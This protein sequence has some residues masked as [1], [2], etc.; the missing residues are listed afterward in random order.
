M[1]SPNL[2]ELVLVESKSARDGRLSRMT[3]DA[4]NSA[5][6]KA[7]AIIFAS[8]QGNGLAT[9]AQMA[10]F[11]EV[12]VDAIESAYRRDKEELASDGAKV[13]RGKALKDVSAFLTETSKAP[14]LT[15]YP[16][17]AALRLG[18]L[19][20]DSGVA[21]QVRNVLLD[22]VEAVPAIAGEM[23]KMQLQNENLKLENENLK[24]RNQMI[25]GAQM[26][27]TISPG[28]GALALGDRDAIVSVERTIERHVIVNQSGQVVR[29]HESLPLG[30]V[31]KQLGMKQAKDLESFLVSCDRAD[32]IQ[33]DQTIISSKRIEKDS[34]R[35]IRKLWGSR[36]GDRQKVIGE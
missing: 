15:V 27:D 35:E 30:T 9:T 24:L 16:P 10:E 36:C 17:R 18:M 4:A 21:K 33:D 12:S 31:A 22:V 26:L 19:L 13:L 20:R 6:N 5:L 29:E 11:Y 25:A 34:V 2:S 28:L 3:N 32:L 8:C 7:K 1:A 23:A 14:S